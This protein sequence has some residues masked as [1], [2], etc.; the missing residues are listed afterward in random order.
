M[1]DPNSDRWGIPGEF[2]YRRMLILGLVVAVGTGI[3]IVVLLILGPLLSDS[4]TFEPNRPSCLLDRQFAVHMKLPASV[5]A[6]DVVSLKWDDREYGSVGMKTG[7]QLDSIFLTDT[8]KQLPDGS[9]EGSIKLEADDMDFL[10]LTSKTA[11]NR[12]EMSIGDHKIEIL[13]AGR[14]VIVSGKYTVT[15]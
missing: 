9:W 8:W 15:D 3:G 10:C 1:Q 12:N 11:G 5:K 6:G 2:I 14:K 13:D 7:A 4:I